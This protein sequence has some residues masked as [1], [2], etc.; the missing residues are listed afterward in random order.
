V[1]STETLPAGA[2]ED[3]SVGEADADLAALMSAW[4]SLPVHVRRV[5]AHLACEEA[6]RVRRGWRG[7]R[8]PAFRKE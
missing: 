6:E 5:L 2:D 3:A 8:N 4:P 7:R 1:S